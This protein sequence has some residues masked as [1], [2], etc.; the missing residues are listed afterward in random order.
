MGSNQSTET[1]AHEKAAFERLRA[2]QLEKKERLEEDYVYVNYEKANNHDDVQTVLHSREPE[3]VP[4]ARL[5]EWQ[6]KLLKD[7]KNR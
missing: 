3:G 2:L 4:V 5:A 1:T 6:D 7:P